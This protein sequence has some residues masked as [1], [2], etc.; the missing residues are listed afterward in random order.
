MSSELVFVKITEA[1]NKLAIWHFGTI[2]EL[3]TEHIMQLMGPTG[4]VVAEGICGAAIVVD[5]EGD[6]GVVGFFQLGEQGGEGLGDM[7]SSR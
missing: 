2:I 6:G 4:G 3:H 5:S 1:K 7:P